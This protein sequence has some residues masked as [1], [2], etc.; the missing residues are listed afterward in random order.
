[1]RRSSQTS[2]LSAASGYLVLCAVLAWRLI[3]GY[4]DI[5]SSLLSAVVTLGVSIAAYRVENRRLLR[6]SIVFMIS[7]L[8]DAMFHVGAGQNI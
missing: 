2:A 7:Y 8:S 4:G 5:I 1:M 6:I 3:P